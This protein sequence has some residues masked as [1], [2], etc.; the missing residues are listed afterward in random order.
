MGK[1]SKDDHKVLKDLVQDCMLGKYSEKQALDYI[2]N[3]LKVEVSAKTYYN[4]KNELK[5]DAHASVSYLKK[6]GF[7]LEAEQR[8]DELKRNYHE[9]TILKEQAKKIKKLV[10]RVKALHDIEMSLSSITVKLAEMY[11]ALPFVAAVQTKLKKE[12]EQ[13]HAPVPESS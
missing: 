12:D 11:D 3:K 1:F 10:D 5:E 6:E 2:Y 8:I 13:E 7:V 4:I 9:L